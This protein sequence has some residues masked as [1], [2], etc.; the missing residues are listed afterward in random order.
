MNLTVYKFIII[1]LIVY[2]EQVFKSLNFFYKIIFTYSL[3]FLY[4]YMA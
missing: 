3:V 4:V 1:Y 2:S